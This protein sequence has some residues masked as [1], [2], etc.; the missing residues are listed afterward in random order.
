MCGIVCMGVCF[1]RG[2]K[3]CSEIRGGV[4][5][6]RKIHSGGNRFWGAYFYCDRLHCN[7]A[8]NITRPDQ[9][10]TGTVKGHPKIQFY[11]SC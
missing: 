9:T 10:N 5:I 2:S 1:Q 11:F 7:L 4:H 8:T 3:F 6:F